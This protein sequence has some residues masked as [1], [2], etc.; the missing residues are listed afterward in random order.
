MSNSKHAPWPKHPDGRPMKLGEM[1]R[2]QRMLH[3]RQAFQQ[4]AA[5][6]QANAPAIA[7]VLTDFDAEQAAI[8]A[9]TTR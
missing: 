3:A 7:K 1:A 4:V 8:A 5:E 2:D 9:A 6:M